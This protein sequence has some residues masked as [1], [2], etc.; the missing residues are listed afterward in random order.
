MD[1]GW[2]SIADDYTVLV[3]NDLPDHDDYRF[4]A[5]CEGEKI[6]LPSVAE[7]APDAM[8]LEEHRKLMQFE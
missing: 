5:E 6:R 7:A 3:R 4:I 1:A 2:I 8:Y